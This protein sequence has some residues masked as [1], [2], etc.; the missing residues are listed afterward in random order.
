MLYICRC[1]A[2]QKEK[3]RKSCLRLFFFYAFFS[4]ASL[5]DRYGHILTLRKKKERTV[6]D[7]RSIAVFPTLTAAERARRALAAA[8]IPAETV[9]VD[10][11]RTRRGCS[12]GVAFSDIQLRGVMAVFGN[13]GIKTREIISG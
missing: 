12:W 8:A 3:E 9:K 2:E 7:V 13:A 11:S 1:P 10:S 6:T 5:Y 4:P